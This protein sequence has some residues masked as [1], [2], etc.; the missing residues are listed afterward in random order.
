MKRGTTSGY[1][2]G[3]TKTPRFCRKAG[4]EPDNA[5]AT[6]YM[7]SDLFSEL[8]DDGIEPSEYRFLHKRFDPSRVALQPPAQFKTPPPLPPAEAVSRKLDCCRGDC[9]DCL[10]YGARPIAG[11]SEDLA[12][13]LNEFKFGHSYRV[14]KTEWPRSAPVSNGQTSCWPELSPFEEELFLEVVARRQQDDYL[15]ASLSVKKGP[16]LA[17]AIMLE[18]YRRLEWAKELRELFP[19]HC[20]RFCKRS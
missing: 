19:L 16:M 12:Q 5:V 20:A 4:G 1:K 13:V 9:D 18:E 11:I 17:A 2:N 14:S 15:E 3:N 7:S 6:H 10:D 8:S